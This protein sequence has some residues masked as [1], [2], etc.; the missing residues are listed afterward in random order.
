LH[1]I[2]CSERCSKKETRYLLFQVFTYGGPEGFPPQGDLET[3]VRDIVTRIGQTGDTHNKLGVCF[4]PVVFGYSDEDIRAYIKTA[5]AIARR[6][7]V[8]ISFHIECSFF[9]GSISP[10]WIA[11]VCWQNFEALVFL[12]MISLAETLC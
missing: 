9:A 10:D 12:Y 6:N 3:S 4:G 7:D 8:A 11:K 1:P 2:G 5:F